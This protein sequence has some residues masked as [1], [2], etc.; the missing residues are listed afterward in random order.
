MKAII[1]ARV[2]TQEQEEGYSIPAQIKRMCD[3]A[4]KK[5]LPVDKV[6]KITESSS[7]EVRTKFN[8]LISYIKSSHETFCLITDTVD[9]L[10]RSFRETPILDDL[11]KKGKIEMHFLRE[12]LILNKNTNR[13]MLTFWDMSVLLASSY[14]RNIGDNVYRSMAYC[15]K[16]GKCM[17]K[18]PFGYKKDYSL[19]PHHSILVKKVFDLYGTGTYSFE[20][21]VKLLSHEYKFTKRGIQTILRNEFYMGKVKFSD[22]R[23]EHNY[24]KIISKNKFDKI[25]TILKK[26]C[27]SHRSRDIYGNITTP[28][29]VP[30][31]QTSIF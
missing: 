17:Y 14:V 12:N 21:I 2:S 29:E 30:K 11:R 22:G 13:S 26:R 1:F 25:Q 20:Q 3:Y 8:E 28:G 7:Q 27:K 15:A 4:Q 24:P 10:Q 9:R 19:D 5:L 18:H 23:Y 16:E 6:I 31:G